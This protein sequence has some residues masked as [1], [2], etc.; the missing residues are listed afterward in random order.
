MSENLN[1]SSSAVTTL[2]EVPCSLSNL[3]SIATNIP[4]TTVP[5]SNSIK[6][7]NAGLLV[8]SRGYIPVSDSATNTGE[9]NR[10]AAVPKRAIAS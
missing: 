9:S 6:P 4:Q 7:Q 2:S 5:T 10:A 3:A 8:M 1:L